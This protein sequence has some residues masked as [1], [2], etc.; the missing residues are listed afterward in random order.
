MNGLNTV[1][2]NNLVMDEA[3]WV[4]FRFIW[5]KYS[6]YYNEM[7]KMAQTEAKKFD[8]SPW[9]KIQRF[10]YVDSSE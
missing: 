8:F 6:V 3:M 5:K 7:L 1:N 9:N 10:Y 4:S 2:I